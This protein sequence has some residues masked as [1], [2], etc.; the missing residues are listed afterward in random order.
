MPVIIEPPEPGDRP[1]PL[2]RRL[3]WFCGLALA[4]AVGTAIGAEALR[5]LLLMH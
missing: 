5:A 3:A 2:V 1:T 4:S